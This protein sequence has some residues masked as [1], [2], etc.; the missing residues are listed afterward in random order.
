MQT[1]GSPCQLDNSHQS[2]SCKEVKKARFT[3]KLV[4][5]SPSPTK[6]GLLVV[7]GADVHVSVPQRHYVESIKGSRALNRGF[8]R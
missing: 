4:K 5:R 7:T 3:L 6:G 2:G 1:V 8:L